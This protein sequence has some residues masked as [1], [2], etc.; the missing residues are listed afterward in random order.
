MKITPGNCF[1]TKRPS[2]QDFQSNNSFLMKNFHYNELFCVQRRRDRSHFVT[3]IMDKKRKLIKKLLFE[4]I[5]ENT[6]KRQYLFIQYKNHEIE[7]P[8]I[9][10]YCFIIFSES[11]LNCEKLQVFSFCNSFYQKKIL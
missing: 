3:F 7:F 6:E 10:L 11:S 5:I 9:Y 8:K 1:P 2:K 4:Y